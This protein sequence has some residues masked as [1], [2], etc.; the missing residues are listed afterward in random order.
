LEIARLT[1]FP[2]G[3]K[4]MQA[5]DLTASMG[6][7]EKVKMRLITEGNRVGYLE[8]LTRIRNAVLVGGLGMLIQCSAGFAQAPDNSKTNQQDRGSATADQQAE[9]QGD[10][11]LA[12]K[13]RKSIMDDKNLSTYARNI[14]VITRNGTVTLRGPVRTDDEKSAIEAKAVEIAGATNVKSEI[15]VKS[16]TEN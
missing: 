2:A 6:N 3:C 7:K 14:E 1:R 4:V 15:T 11:D 13:I 8:W 10:R 12:R 9:N 5:S 16:K